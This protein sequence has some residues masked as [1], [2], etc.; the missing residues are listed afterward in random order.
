MLYRKDLEKKD[1]RTNSP[2]YKQHDNQHYNQLLPC[3]YYTFTSQLLYIYPAKGTQLQPK[4]YTVA[5]QKVHSCNP[6]G[7]QLQRKRYTVATQK[8]YSW[9]G[10]AMRLQHDRFSKGPAMTLNAWKVTNNHSS[11]E[12]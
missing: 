3:N 7:T 10:E 12:N 2:M 5:T 9:N 11:F 1:A 4:R 8:V 6:K